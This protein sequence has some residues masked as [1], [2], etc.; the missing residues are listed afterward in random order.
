[1]QLTWKD[2]VKVLIRS[3]SRVSTQFL[4]VNS[5]ADFSKEL[6][7]WVTIPTTYAGGANSG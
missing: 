1:M 6:G 7:E 3:S 2:Y 4:L 5:L